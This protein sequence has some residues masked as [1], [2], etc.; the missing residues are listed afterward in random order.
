MALDLSKIQLN[1]MKF[2][3]HVICKVIFCI[4]DAYL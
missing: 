4:F 3:E 1:V 2:R